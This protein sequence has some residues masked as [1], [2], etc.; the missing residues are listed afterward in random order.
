MDSDPPVNPKGKFR[1]FSQ[2]TYN[3]SCFWSLDYSSLLIQNPSTY[4]DMPENDVIDELFFT[5]YEAENMEDMQAPLSPLHS[6][7]PS[8]SQSPSPTQTPSLIH[9]PTNLVDTQVPK[10]STHEATPSII[11][12]INI[13][14]EPI[15][16]L[17]LPDQFP[18]LKTYTMSHNKW[19][20]WVILLLAAYLHTK[21]HMTF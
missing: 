18:P 9:D 12:A 17:T 1:L 15:T 11:P 21:H 5:I 10:V 6:H 3:L 2:L 14:H 16:I 19:Y 20:I 7:A 8:S 13:E 4:E